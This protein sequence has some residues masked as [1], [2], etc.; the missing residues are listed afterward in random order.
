MIFSLFFQTQRSTLGSLTLDVLVNEELELP[1][2]VTKYPVEDGGPDVS[3]HITQGNETIKI[4]GSISSSDMMAI[5][6]GGFTGGGCKSKLVDAIEMLR[7]MHKDRKPITVV[8]G[9]GVYEDMG[10]TGVSIKR[11][12][13]QDKG[14]G[15]IDIDASLIKVIKVSLKTADLPPEQVSGESTQGKTGTT[16]KA[17]GTSGKA[18]QPPN[19]KEKRVSA[20]KAADKGVSEK[21]LGGY[22]GSFIPGSS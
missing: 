22:L 8:T 19:T 17:A 18:D 9:L 1:S 3:D 20:W 16:E 5:E 10:F 11:S 13:S 15:W 12:N 7:D 2:E 4:G 6:F 21:G 14:G